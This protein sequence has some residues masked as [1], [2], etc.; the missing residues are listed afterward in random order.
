M[1]VEIYLL[2]IM[3]VVCCLSLMVGL[4]AIYSI[5]ML[6]DTVHHKVSA[7]SKSI[8]ENLSKGNQYGRRK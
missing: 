8:T 4:Y 3:Y 7:L 5:S 1:F 2:L 6:K